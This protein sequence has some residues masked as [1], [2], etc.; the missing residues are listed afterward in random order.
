MTT[1]ASTDQAVT[2]DLPSIAK[3]LRAE[4]T[5]AREGKASRTLVRSEDLRLVLVAL[6]AGQSIAE[7]H[8]SVTASVQ[9]LSGHIR[10]RLPDRRVEVP[11]GRLLVL[12]PGVPHDVQAEPDSTFLLTL[13]WPATH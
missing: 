11:V 13:G 5:Y 3:K 4:P 8:A 9:T 7:H 12:G 1:L 2:F 6:E 10:L